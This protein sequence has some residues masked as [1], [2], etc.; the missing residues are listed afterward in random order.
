MIRARLW[1]RCA[2]VHDPVTPVIVSPAVIGWDWHQKQQRSILPGQIID[3]RIEDVRT[4]YTSEDVDQAMNLLR[5]Y[6]VRYIYVGP[7]ERMYYGGSGL[8]KFA[9]E[10][11]RL[12]N[13]V[14]QN[15]QVQIYSVAGSQ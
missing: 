1:F 12:W 15:E 13:L 11:G 9:R 8:D 4:I 6:G 7:L 14:Y 3:R 5:R 10:Q 2:A